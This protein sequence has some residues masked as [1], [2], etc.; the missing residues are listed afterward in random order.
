MSVQEMQTREHFNWPTLFLLVICGAV[1]FSIGWYG[2]P[3]EQS[4]NDLLKAGFTIVDPEG[5]EVEKFD[6]AE[7][8]YWT[9]KPKP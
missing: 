1:W 7:I 9:K 6:G 3:T 2:K 8:D 4:A 5:Y